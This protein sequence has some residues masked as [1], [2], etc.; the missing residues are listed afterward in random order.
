MAPDKTVDLLREWIFVADFVLKLSEP[1]AFQMFPLFMRPSNAYF[2]FVIV[3]LCPCYGFQSS[4]VICEQ[5]NGNCFADVIIYRDRKIL[6]LWSS[7][8]IMQ[9]TIGQEQWTRFILLESWVELAT[10]T[11][12][13]EGVT[14]WSS[15][16]KSVYDSARLLESDESGCKSMD[17]AADFVKNTPV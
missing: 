9:A 17:I 7:H 3:I 5:I 10:R 4:A 6:R 8:R 2:L 13:K 14:L 1:A 11:K 12:L 15:Q 16:I